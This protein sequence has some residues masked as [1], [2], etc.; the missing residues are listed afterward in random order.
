MGIYIPAIHLVSF[1]Q[2][3][4]ILIGAGQENIEIYKVKL[5]ADRFV[6]WDN[7]GSR[8]CKLYNMYL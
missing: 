5:T 3:Y 4:S 6:T 8:A 2:D 1:R 7:Y